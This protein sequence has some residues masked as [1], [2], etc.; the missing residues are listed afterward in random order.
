MVKPVAG[1]ENCRFR[2]IVRT[3][4]HVSVN[5]DPLPIKP[6]KIVVQKMLR[7]IQPKTIVINIHQGGKIETRFATTP[8]P[9]MVQQAAVNKSGSQPAKARGTEESLTKGRHGVVTRDKI[10]QIL[11]FDKV[12]QKFC[13]K[14]GVDKATMMGVLVPDRPKT[15]LT[16][17][18]AFQSVNANSGARPQSTSKYSRRE[19]DVDTGKAALLAYSNLDNQVEDA[20][21]QDWR[22]NT[23]N[24]SA[25]N[26]SGEKNGVT[27]Q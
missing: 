1:I 16:V 3:I 10:K 8:E 9:H 24:S 7:D 17:E 6:A 20:N 26:L 12:L 22:R 11:K 2:P 5:M 19:R 13:D 4:S 14:I 25:K 23:R 27:E 21:S 15:E 18:S